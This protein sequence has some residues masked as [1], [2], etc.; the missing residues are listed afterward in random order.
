MAEANQRQGAAD[1]RERLARDIH[2]TLAQGFASI[3]VLAEA[4]RSGVR[5]D[6]DRSAQQLVSIERTARE[7]LAE[8]RALVGA[9]PRAGAAP[10]TL[11]QALRRTL[12]RFAQDTGLTV[13]AE[14]PD[15]AWRPA[16]P[17][18]AA[19][20]RPGVAGQRPQAR[21]GVHGRPGARGAAVRGGTGTHR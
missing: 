4:A 20:L 2:D 19:V 8:A 15:V 21:G 6:P 13:T 3:I 9:A 18:R 1:E 16:D 7:N 10:G 12:D 5:T 17:D 11:A 14:L